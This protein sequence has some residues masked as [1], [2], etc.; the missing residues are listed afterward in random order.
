MLFNSIEFFIFLPIVFTLFWSIQSYSLRAGNCILLGASYLFYGWWDWR[1]LSLIAI[2]SLADFL[3]GQG[4]AS[5]QTER[6][7]RG[8]V[9]VSLLVN[10]GILGF[11][12]YFNFFIDSSSLKPSPTKPSP[13]RRKD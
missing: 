10:L 8:L 4:I 5:I 1:F 3:I 7:R 9:F 12:K 2:S 6:A 13:R 11:F